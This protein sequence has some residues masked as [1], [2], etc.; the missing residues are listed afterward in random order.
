MLMA[1]KAYA[2]VES[3][4]PLTN[5]ELRPRC[6][7]EHHHSQ[8]RPELLQLLMLGLEQ[9]LAPQ[10]ALHLRMSRCL[11]GPSQLQSCAGH[12]STASLTYRAVNRSR[13][14]IVQHLALSRGPSDH[15]C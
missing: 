13:K 9:R 14:L 12:P 6:H 3:Q 4:Q 11:F 7:Q 5:I 1:H 2:T 8:V 15:L 10:V